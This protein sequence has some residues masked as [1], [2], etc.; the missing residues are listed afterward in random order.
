LGHVSN[1]IFL[2]ATACNALRVLAIVQVSVR[3][4]VCPSGIL[5]ICIK[6]VQARIT[7]SSLW[8]TTKLS[9]FVTKFCATRWRV[10]LERGCQRGVPVEKR[11]CALLLARLSSSVKTVAD[12]YRHVA[13]HNK[14][15]SLDF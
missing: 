3:P 1:L 12:R 8:A 2:R 9:F 5:L 15:W 6:T 7:K 14:H 10:P 13:Y 11:C 4:S